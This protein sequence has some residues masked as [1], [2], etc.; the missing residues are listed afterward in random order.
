MK[1]LLIYNVSI[2][3]TYWQIVWCQRAELRQKDQSVGRWQI[4][5]SDL[6][7]RGNGSPSRSKSASH[8]STQTT[9]DVTNTRTIG[10]AIQG[11]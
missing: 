5:H 11:A 2:R 7:S 3:V 9:D 10:V 6:L 4:G 1:Y 8:T